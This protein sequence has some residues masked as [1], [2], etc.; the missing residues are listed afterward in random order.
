MSSRGDL[1]PDQVRLWMHRLAGWVADHRDTIEQ[2]RVTPDVS[3]ED[4][5]A[6]FAAPPPEHPEKLAAILEDVERFI[7]PGLVHAGHPKFLTEHGASLTTPGIVGEW[8]AVV[9]GAGVPASPTTTALE[10]T[11]L[12][13][14]RTVLGLADTFEGIVHDCAAA[15]TLHALAAARNTAHPELRRRGLTGAPK[16]MLYTSD[17]AHESVEQAA[18]TLGL[19]AD[20]VRYIETDG[21]LRLRPAALRAAIA[22][23]VH[24]RLRPLAVVA[25]VGTPSCGAVDPVPAIADV[26]AEQGLWLHVDASHGSALAVLPEGRWVLDGVG[27][28]DSVVIGAHEWLFVPPDLTALYTR[29]PELLEIVARRERDGVAA[30]KAWVALRAVGRA[31]L[32]ARIREHVRLA[33]RFADWVAA[34][35]DFELTAPTTM[36]VV[37]FRARPPGMSDDELNELNRRLVRQVTSGGRAYLTEAHAGGAVAMRI[38]IANVLTAESHLADAWTLIHDAFDRTLID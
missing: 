35:P 2:Q 24:A 7:V 12:R 4:I 32:E 11:T 30:L 1:P 9:L 8:L 33:R 34:D 5:T 25:T 38:G 13:W 37:C 27:R 26:C 18:V 29:R 6:A 3:P 10:T 20:S 36:A 23:D 16:L 15:A 21:E 19:G 14:I 22:R 28:G 17:Q 31:E